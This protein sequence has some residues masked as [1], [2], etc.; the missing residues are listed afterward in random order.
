MA[1]AST[2][3]ARQIGRQ[4]DPSLDMPK[5]KEEYRFLKGKY[6]VTAKDFAE[7]SGVP[8]WTVRD[9]RKELRKEPVTIHVEKG[10]PHDEILEMMRQSGLSLRSFSNASG[11]P[12]YTLRSWY[13]K[14]R[15][16]DFR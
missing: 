5:L 4:K 9:W 10:V 14:R 11:I 12:Y 13:R 8:Y 1:A 2:R 6:G 16:R 7:L 3:S 15:N